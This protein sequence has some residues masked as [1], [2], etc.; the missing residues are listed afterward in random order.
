MQ[1]QLNIV[2][3]ADE[4]TTS[5]EI[6]ALASRAQRVETPC[7][8]GVMVWRIWGS[9]KA[10]VLGHGAQGAWTHWIRNIDALA[11]KCKVIAP[12]LP[13]CGESALPR[14]AN[15]ADIS[16]ALAEGLRR[17]LG[18]GEQAD[19]VGF[20]LSGTVFAWL[21]SYFPRLVRRV[22]LVGAGGLN[23]PRGHVELRRASGLV[24]E[25]REAVIRSNL[26]ALMLHHPQSADALAL[27][28]SAM[29]GKRSRLAPISLVLPDR[30]LEVLPRLTV[31]VDAIW[32]EFDSPH[33]D[34]AVQEAVLRQIQPEL[35]FRVIAG[36]GHWAMYEKPDAFN[37][38]LSAILDTPLRVVRTQESRPC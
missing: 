38:A 31:P 19:M 37:S 15:H 29:N 25:E 22:V 28:I 24:G 2:T 18:E 12:D 16:E 21:A 3:S 20:S 27:Y 13:G 34:P 9:G 17:I 4:A 11:A 36:A 6:A 1:G 23:T 33:P 35:D 10:V 8:D 5:V 30:L 7:G 14:S 26:L 32:G